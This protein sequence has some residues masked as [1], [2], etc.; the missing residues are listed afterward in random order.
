M[1]RNYDKEKPQTFKFRHQCKTNFNNFPDIIQ[2][3]KTHTKSHLNRKKFDNRI[4]T[5]KK[6]RG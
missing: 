6:N 5:D 3:N 2:N 4:P 1:C